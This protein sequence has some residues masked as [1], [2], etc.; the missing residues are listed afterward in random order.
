MPHVEDRGHPGP[1]SKVTNHQL[2][3]RVGCNESLILSFCMC[4]LQNVDTNA[5][6]T[7][8]FSTFLNS[9]STLAGQ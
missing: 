7:A 6:L 9:S 5:E 8:K 3:P 2:Q 1:A 4:R